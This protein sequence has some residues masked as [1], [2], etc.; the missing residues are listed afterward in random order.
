MSYYSTKLYPFVEE[1]I[2]SHNEDSGKKIYELSVDDLDSFEQEQFARHLI[3]HNEMEPNFLWDMDGVEDIVSETLALLTNE[4]VDDQINFAD[5]FKSKVVEF[6][7]KR[8][9]AM[10]D[11]V[12][13]WVEQEDMEEMGYSRSGHIDNGESYW[14]R[15]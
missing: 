7:K 15:N 13:G 8:M 10:I 9:Q 11:D 4:S 14:V 12:I 3:I 1:L 2:R 5:L 6:Y